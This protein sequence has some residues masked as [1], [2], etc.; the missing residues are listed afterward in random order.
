M[1]KETKINIL[2][3]FSLTLL[4]ALITLGGLIYSSFK[5]ET[6][7]ASNSS[8]VIEKSGYINYDGQ[9]LKSINGRKVVLLFK[10]NWCSSC[11]NLEQDILQNAQKI[12]S[13]LTILK[14]DYDKEFELRK[15]YKVN[16][17]H[18]LVQIDNEGKAINITFAAPTL[19]KI[20]Q[21][22]K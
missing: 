16:I 21:D 3:V 12:P 1:K 14:I 6:V 20:I 18:T 11:T 10:A 17:Q 8:P 19:D 15:L 13:N 4:F 2:R 5:T 22:L 9:Q 7:L